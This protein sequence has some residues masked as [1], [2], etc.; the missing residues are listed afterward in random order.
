MDPQL[1]EIVSQFMI[2]GPCG[3]INKKKNLLACEKTSAKKTFQNHTKVKEFF[4][5]IVFQFI[6]VDVMIENLLLRME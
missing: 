3:H 1:Y 2:H 5:P 6:G 4:I